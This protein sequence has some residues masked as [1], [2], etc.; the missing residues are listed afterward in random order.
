MPVPSDLPRDAS[1]Y[2][3]HPELEPGTDSSRALWALG[4]ALTLTT[5]VFDWMA[6]GTLT[7]FFDLCFV[8]ICLA[9]ALRARHGAFYPAAA[10]PP[11]LMFAMLLLVA[12]TDPGIIADPE[13]GVAQAF[14]SGLAHHAVGF[15][16][17]FA[18]TLLVL[19]WRSGGA[20]LNQP[21]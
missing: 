9:L 18:L 1:T 3:D 10:M 2:L 8:W 19:Q 21:R 14:V 15:A 5:V 6:G 7:W 16:A 17:G 13:D 12:I 4:A 11:V 20:F